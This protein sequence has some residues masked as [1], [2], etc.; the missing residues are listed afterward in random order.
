FQRKRCEVKDI[1]SSLVLFPLALREELLRQEK[2]EQLNYKFEKK[3]G[4]ARGLPQGDDPRCCPIRGI[5]VR[6]MPH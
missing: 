2:L 1:L 3:S 4:A 6:W 5:C